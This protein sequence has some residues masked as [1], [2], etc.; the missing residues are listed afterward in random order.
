M[1]VGIRSSSDECCNHGSIAINAR[2]PQRCRAFTVRDF[3][4][5]AGLDQHVH[6]FFVSMVCSPMKRSRAIRLG[7][8]HIGLLL[9]QSANRGL[10]AFHGGIRNVAADGTKR[11]DG[12]E[13]HYCAAS[14]YACNRHMKRLPP[15]TVGSSSYEKMCHLLERS[16]IIQPA[17]TIADA[18]L[19]NVESVEDA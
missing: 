10:I 17:P 7:R 8:I 3:C 12:Q 11:G 16:Q 14:D 2:Q 19:M 9:N 1:L 13:H 18:F 5:R 15:I 6:K 4:V